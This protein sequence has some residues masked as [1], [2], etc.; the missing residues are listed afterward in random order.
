[1]GT[2]TP[3]NESYRLFEHVSE[4]A[5]LCCSI[6]VF[7]GS[8]VRISVDQKENLVSVCRLTA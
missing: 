2:E 1:M 8:P 3:G 7:F 6:D 5:V 4:I